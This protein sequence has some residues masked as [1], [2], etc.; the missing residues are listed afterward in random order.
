MTLRVAVV[1]C[2]AIAH[3]HVPAIHE[4]PNVEIVG[5]YDRDA[6]RAREL[7]NQFGISRVFDSWAEAPWRS[8]Y[9]RRRPAASAR[10]PSRLR[11]R[12]A[13]G[14]QARR[15]REAARDDA[16]GDRTACARPPRQAGRDLI[17]CH[18]RL[19]E[20]RTE[21]MAELLARGAIGD[22]YMVQSLGL[23]PPS[24][25]GVRPWLGS[26]HG[27]GGVLMAQ[28]VHIAYLMRH[29]AG[30][31]AEVSAFRGERKV[32]QIVRRGHRS[33]HPP[34]RERRRR[35]DARHVRAD[36]R[37]LRTRD[38][39]LRYR[40]VSEL[41]PEVGPGAARPGAVRRLAEDVRRPRAPPR[42]A[43]RRAPSRDV[44]GGCGPTSARPSRKGALP[45]S[46]TRT[47]GRQ[48][49]SSSQH[50]GP[51]TKTAPCASRYNVGVFGP[52]LERRP[53]RRVA[54]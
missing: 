4:S 8:S 10:P 45:G 46:P 47:G 33:R 51:P 52:S 23:E 2:G 48:S 31:V 17:P 32:V 43:A 35:G 12:G 39:S 18:T 22:V 27:G 38:H 9:R 19:Y 15:C 30:E 50:T 1:G 34:L 24:I 42:R 29:L 16:R 54:V 20:S 41:R 49:R 25:V 6:A 3:V 21:R 36:G 40:G 44:P 11:R 13:C 37:S 7:A 5:V 14:R 28:S 53:A 26:G